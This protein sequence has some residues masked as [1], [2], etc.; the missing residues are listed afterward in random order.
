MK[1]VEHFIKG[2][3][4]LEKCED[5]LF[6]S[7]HFVAVID[8]VTSKSDF[9]YNGKTTGKLAA[10]LIK[11]QL[12]CLE[13]DATIQTFLAKV[14]RCFDAFYNR[15][16]FPYEKSEKGLQAVCVVYSRWH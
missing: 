11:E 4:G 1:V 14:N 10:E 15:I 7:E 16:S 3:K 12:E 13:E 6:I 9:T 2:K 8:G 5:A